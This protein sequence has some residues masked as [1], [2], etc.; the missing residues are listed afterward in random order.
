MLFFFFFFPGLL[1]AVIVHWVRYN[2]VRLQYRYKGR[3]EGLEGLLLQLL[4][5]IRFEKL[6]LL[7]SCEFREAT[8]GAPYLTGSLAV[9][10]C[11]STNP[12]ELYKE[13]VAH[14]AVGLTGSLVSEIQAPKD[15]H[16]KIT[17]F[18][19]LQLTPPDSL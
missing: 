2:S 10:Q 11:S 6:Q 18:Q 15:P 17:T 3:L 7:K 13:C 9:R 12:V 8:F 14:M 1:L 4:Q 16:S 5:A 19:Q